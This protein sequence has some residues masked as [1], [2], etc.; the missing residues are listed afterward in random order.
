MREIK[1]RAWDKTHKKMLDRVL[2]GPGD[3]CSIVW[4]EERP[5]WVNFD[6]ACGVIMQFTGL[7]DKHGRE[8]YEGDIVFNP[9]C[10]VRG[11]VT[12]MQKFATYIVE[13]IDDGYHYALHD[14][15]QVIGNV[16]EHPEMVEKRGEDEID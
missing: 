4:D 6:D 9:D 11:V 8:I 3:P 13:P 12:W 7:L 10:D 16:W 14:A 5:G 2:A 15:W 1:F